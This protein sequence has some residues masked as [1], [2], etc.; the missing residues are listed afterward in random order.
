MND[1]FPIAINVELSFESLAR[2][3]KNDPSIPK[4]PINNPMMSKV[5]PG[6]ISIKDAVRKIALLQKGCEIRKY[7][8]TAIARKKMPIN[9][10]K[11]EEKISQLE[12]E[13]S[14]ISGEY[15]TK[16]GIMNP[17]IARRKAAQ[18]TLFGSAF[19]IPAPT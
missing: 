3:I 8:S 7:P 19:A 18:P 15:T 11:E 9:A 14:S 5:M 17:A 1:Y 12:S 6:I 16:K 2:R 10:E 4:T 13:R